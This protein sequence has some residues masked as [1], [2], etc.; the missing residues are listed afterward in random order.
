[1]TT[2]DETMI[3]INIRFFAAA[4]ERADR[5]EERRG[6]PRASTVAD[7]KRSLYQQHPSLEA[8]DPYLRWAVNHEFISGDEHVLQPNDEVALIPPISGG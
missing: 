7:L 3:M 8:I 2:H 4:R 5:S 6:I 1:M